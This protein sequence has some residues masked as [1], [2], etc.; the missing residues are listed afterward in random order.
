MAICQLIPVA[1]AMQ[2]AAYVGLRA[3][4]VAGAAARYIVFCLLAFLL[5][6]ILFAFSVDFYEPLYILIEPNPELS[7]CPE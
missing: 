1:L 5:I 6:T 2:M 7:Y 3:R 4:R